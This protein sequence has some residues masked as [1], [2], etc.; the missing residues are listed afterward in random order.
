MHSENMSK[1]LAYDTARR[2][3]YALRQEE[4]IEKR[5]QREEAR[6][7]G[8]YFGPN[9][10]QISQTLEDV[11]FEKWKAWAQD[12][13]DKADASRTAAYANFGEEGSDDIEAAPLLEE[14]ALP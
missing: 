9:K 5:V 2:E 7:V 4:E 14:E 6:H 11:Q 1:D 8:A 12:E 10:L 3:F 13:V